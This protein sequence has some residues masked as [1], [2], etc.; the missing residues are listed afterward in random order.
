MHN[1][2]KISEDLYY[3]GVSDR[4]I[5]LFERMLP[6]PNGMTYNSYLLKDKHTVLFDTADAAVDRQFF[7]N[8]KGALDGRDL[9]YLVIHHV[10]PDHAALIEPLLIRYPNCKVVT[11][12]KVQQF[13][14]QFFGPILE[15]R[16]QLVKEGD[17][18]CT[19][20]HTLTWVMAPMVHWPEVMVTYDT[21]DHILFSADAFGSFGALN[22]NIF[23]DEV[24]YERD[25][26]EDS[27]RYFL[28]IVGKYG[29]QVQNILKK[30]S[31]LDIKMICPLH[32]VI[33]RSNLGFILEKYNTW[34][35][36]QPEQKGVL[37]LYASMYGNT[38]SAVS[39]LATKLAEKGVKEIQIMNVSRKHFS[40][41]LAAAFQWSHIVFASP[42][43]NNGL[44]PMMETLLSD[45]KAHLWQNRTV[46]VI[47]NGSWAPCSGKLMTEYLC[48]MKNITLLGQQLSLKSSLKD[49]Q[50]E[51]LNA[52]A[53]ALVISLKK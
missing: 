27:R 6:T 23:N 35:S 2:R 12:C 53:D 38:E 47:E 8:L 9:D 29:I 43:Y 48:Q 46:A 10:E 40:D 42:T 36:Y 31:Q 26:M 51:C 44:Y 20:R 21:T 32:G 3:V 13:V 19:G 50:M 39:C 18:L 4:N 11:N 17:T 28:N 37:I 7:E 33:W 30:A 16:V 25:W 1:F 34:S 15:G 22:G 14:E 24:N 41:S 52:L 49:N 45:L 5:D